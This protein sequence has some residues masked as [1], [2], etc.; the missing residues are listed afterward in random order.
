MGLPET[1]KHAEKFAAAL[2]DGDKEAFANTLKD[3]QEYAPQ[4]NKIAHLSANVEFPLIFS[5][6][7]AHNRRLTKV[8]KDQIL[9]K[10]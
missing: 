1:I 4:A 8:E 6:L 5:I 10:H 9:K 7:F 3:A 2:E